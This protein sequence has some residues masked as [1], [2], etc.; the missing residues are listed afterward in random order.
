MITR[1]SHF[2]IWF[3]FF[4]KKCTMRTKQR[5]SSSYKLTF[6]KG[7]VYFGYERVWPVSPPPIPAARRWTSSFLRP[8]MKTRPPAGSG[9][10]VFAKVR[11]Q[12]LPLPLA[13]SVL[14]TGCRW[15]LSGW[16]SGRSGPFCRHWSTAASGRP[17]PPEGRMLCRGQT[18]TFQFH[19]WLCSKRELYSHFKLSAWSLWFNHWIYVRTSELQ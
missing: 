11:P 7:P 18:W 17:A 3:F 4:K 1:Y 2:S 6:N 16:C 5:Q 10:W 19:L 9:S 8:P 15:R 14:E 13:A 12:L